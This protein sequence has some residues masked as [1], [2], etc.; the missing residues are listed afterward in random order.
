MNEKPTPKY[1]DLMVDFGFK[2]IFKESGKKQ[3]LIRPLNEIFDLDIADINIRESEQMGLVRKAHRVSYDL[4]CTD[5][6]GNRFIV[7]VQL[8]DQKFFLERA[9][10]YT[11]VPIAKAMPKRPPKSKSKKQKDQAKKKRLRWNYN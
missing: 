3:L 6:G 11:A 1:I 7:E 8:A 4:L 10:F 9:L 2:K 5:T